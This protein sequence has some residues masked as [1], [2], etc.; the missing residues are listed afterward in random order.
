[1]TK[2]SGMTLC[3]Q[4]I[5][6][7]AAT[8]AHAD[9][10]TTA[11][12]DATNLAAIAAQKLATAQA[13]ANAATAQ[14][15]AQQALVTSQLANQKDQIANIQ[16][17]LATPNISSLRQTGTVAAPAINA[18]YSRLL[19]EQLG[20]WLDANGADTPAAS[21]QGGPCLAVVMS[22]AS[23]STLA[24]AYRATSEKLV[25]TWSVLHAAT[26]SLRPVPVPALVAKPA[27]VVATVKPDKPANGALLAE[28]AGVASLANFALNVAAAAKTQT[29]LSTAPISP[30][31]KLVSAAVV[32][33]LSGIAGVTLYDPDTASQVIGG[34]SGGPATCANSTDNAVRSLSI[35]SQADCVAEAIRNAAA[36]VDAKTA[37]LTSLGPAATPDPNADARAKTAALGTAV[38]QAT[39]D[40]Q[41]M[42][43]PD[44]AT[45][46]IPFVSAIQGESYARTMSA[47]KTCVLSIN[48]ISS[49]ADSLVRDGTFTSYKL[50]LATTT[51][52]SWQVSQPDGKVLKS[53]FK[54]IATNWTKQAL[55]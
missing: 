3:T 42:F 10:T 24:L 4:F 44:K 9:D 54:A 26:E 35:E 52:I 28:A 16:S 27:A 45:G 17:A 22:R 21:I 30:A 48:T 2:R 39:S 38:I 23:L 37:A 41:A 53:G 34:K 18:A 31:S 11:L 8:S 1:M 33:H 20:K 55:D 32:G 46:T 6:L 49:D 29:R 13:N 51:T 36:V 7:V 50:F 15:T 19:S 43:T 25:S 47:E 40:M 14:A 5:L 12:Q